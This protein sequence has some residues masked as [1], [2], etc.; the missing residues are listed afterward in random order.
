MKPV[1]AKI[2]AC[3]LAD[4]HNLFLELL[5][6]FCNNFLDASGVTADL[7][8]GNTFAAPVRQRACAE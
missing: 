1:D 6:C 7:G 4:F 8:S 3:A 5:F 2:D